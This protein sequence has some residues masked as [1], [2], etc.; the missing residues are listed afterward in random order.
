MVAS[1]AVHVSTNT[2]AT[3]KKEN[4]NVFGAEGKKKKK[5][6]FGKRWVY[7]MSGCA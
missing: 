5:K 6:K 1:R 3:V 7:G 4:S 2:E